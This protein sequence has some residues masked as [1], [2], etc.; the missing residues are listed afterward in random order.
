MHEVG[1]SVTEVH[2]NQLTDSS[3]SEIWRDDRMHDVM[4]YDGRYWEVAGFQ[5]RGRLQNEDVIIGISAIETFPSDD[6][7]LDFQPG[8]AVG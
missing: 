3:D 8:T 5:I 1:I 6:M 7:I 4:Y 2:G